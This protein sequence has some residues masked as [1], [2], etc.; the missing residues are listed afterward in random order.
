VKL[1]GYCLTC[2]VL[3]AVGFLGSLIID[4]WK[5]RDGTCVVN[6]PLVYASGSILSYFYYTLYAKGVYSVSGK[7]CLKRTRV[8]EDF[9]SSFMYGDN[10]GGK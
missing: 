4:G 9:Y 2:F 3:V 6:D 5:N 10:S 8:T 7:E 1:S